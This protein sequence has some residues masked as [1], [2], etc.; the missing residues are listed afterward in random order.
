MGIA[1]PAVCDSWAWPP[2]LHPTP[3]FSPGS[4]AGAPGTPGH[5]A[6]HRD[7]GKTVP[8]ARCGGATSQ[9]QHARPHLKG[10]SRGPGWDPT[11]GAAHHTG[12]GEPGLERGSRAEPVI[13]HAVWFSPHRLRH[14]TAGDSG[15][16]RQRRPGMSPGGQAP[17]APRA[18]GAEEEGTASSIQVLPTRAGQRANLGTV[19]A[20]R[21]LLPATST[22][23]GPPG[24]VSSPVTSLHL[25][26]WHQRPGPAWSPETGPWPGEGSPSG[27]LAQAPRLVL[28]ITAAGGDVSSCKPHVEVRRWAGAR[29]ALQ[30]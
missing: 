24:D 3:G 15:G 13:L 2:V 11:G 26:V 9:P 25:G 10:G 7:S 20:V 29:H 12:P 23:T 22:C 14:L 19:R 28:H 6:H 1:R 16:R 21:A 5:C 4:C 8:S 27:A 30:P 18:W 17:P